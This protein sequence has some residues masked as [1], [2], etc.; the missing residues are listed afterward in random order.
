MTRAFL[1]AG[2]FLELNKY[3][4]KIIYKFKHIY[5]KPRIRSEKKIELNSRNNRSDQIYLEPIVTMF[6]LRYK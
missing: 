5:L 3:L 4:Y 1:S 6:Y 2:L